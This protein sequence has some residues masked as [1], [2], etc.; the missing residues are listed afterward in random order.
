MGNLSIMDVILILFGCAHAAFITILYILSL[1][2]A[3]RTVF[4][5]NTGNTNNKADESF[6][7]GKSRSENVLKKRFG[8]RQWVM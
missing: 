7:K 6:E 2:T 1:S 3:E 4:S 8:E 5:K